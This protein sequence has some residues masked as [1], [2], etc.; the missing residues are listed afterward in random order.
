MNHNFKVGDRVA[1]DIDLYSDVLRRGELG[2]VCQVEHIIDFG[3][4]GVCWDLSNEFR[5][6][7]DGNCRYGYGW[8]VPTEYLRHLNEADCLDQSD[9]QP[10]SLEDLFV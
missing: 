3:F 9:L 4:V 1:A 10:L 2:T 7:C 8:Y 5:H 6:E